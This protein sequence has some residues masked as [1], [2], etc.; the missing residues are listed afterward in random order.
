MTSDAHN[1]ETN[2]IEVGRWLETVPLSVTFSSQDRIAGFAAL[3]TLRN[4]SPQK[5][6]SCTALV[7][8]EKLVNTAQAQTEVPIQALVLLQKLVHHKT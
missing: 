5:E 4:A 7:Q 2:L 6:A 1:I 8:L 3:E